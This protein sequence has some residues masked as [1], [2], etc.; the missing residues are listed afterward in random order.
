MYL[1]ICIFSVVALLIFEND[2]KSLTALSAVISS[3]TNVGPGF[4][5]INPHSNYAFFSNQSKKGASLLNPYFTT[6]AYPDKI[7]L[8]GKDSKLV[9]SART[10]FGKN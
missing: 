6:S 7:S 3:I 4:D 5:Q 2:V 9:I 10:N 8:S 1:I